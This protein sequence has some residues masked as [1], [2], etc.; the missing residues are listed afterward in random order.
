M[1]TKQFFTDLETMISNLPSFEWSKKYDT[2]LQFE[3]VKDGIVKYFSIHKQNWAVDIYV[4]SRYS[5][6]E[7]MMGK[8]IKRTSSISFTLAEIAEVIKK[9]KNNLR[10]VSSVEEVYGVKLY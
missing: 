10:G 8:H 5:T 9:L 7:D 1:E 2:Q 3:Y 4:V 6:K